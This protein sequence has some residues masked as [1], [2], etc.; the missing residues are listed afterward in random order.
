MLCPRCNTSFIVKNN[1]ATTVTN[2]IHAEKQT[3]QTALSL[4]ATCSQL[5]S[6]PTDFTIVKPLLEL[7]N[8]QDV[9]QINNA[10]IKM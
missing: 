5:T 3:A 7:L 8:K 2:H 4:F 9:K 1:I 10:R 6:G